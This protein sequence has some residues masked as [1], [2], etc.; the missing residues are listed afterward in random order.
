MNQYRL[1]RMAAAQQ[2]A[3]DSIVRGIQNFEKE[4][5]IDGNCNLAPIK[6]EI[7]VGIPEFFYLDKRIGMSKGLFG[8]KLHFQYLY[9]RNEIE[10]LRRELEDIA[11]E[12]IAERINDHQSEYDKALVL[13]D[14]LKTRAVYNTAATAAFNPLALS[15]EVQES[16]SVVGALIN[17]A[18]VCE[19]FAKAYQFL[20]D[21]AGLECTVISGEIQTPA[22]SGP[23]AWNIV[24]INGY[25][26]HVDVT[27]DSQ[28]VTRPERGYFYFGLDDDTIRRN[29]I[30]NED[31]YV[32][33]PVAP[34]NYF[35]ANDAIIDSAT[36]LKR[37]L[38]DKIDFEENPILF[39]IKQGSA[40]EA[41]E[42]L[43]P[44]AISEVMNVYGRGRVGRMETSM[45][46]EH[47]IMI[48]ELE[49]V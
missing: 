13:Y 8:Q 31:Q 6:E 1:S 25:Y 35:K 12:V 28:S 37:F 29:H 33:C 47:Q 41:D 2:K 14:F 16:F 19:G 5:S 38:K 9:S 15:A 46:S 4:V 11:A 32:K 17:G 22:I 23:H 43:A 3:Y 21:R 36:Q 42:S 48:V 40:L 34:Y 20:C 45:I 24:K 10:R 30:W 26:H 44:A 7:S 18:C 39:K 27:L 49:Y